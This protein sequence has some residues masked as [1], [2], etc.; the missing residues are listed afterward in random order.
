MFKNITIKTKLLGIVLGS[1]IV[2]SIM[3]T[4]QSVIT[5]ENVSK[6]NIEQYKKNAY[7][8]K[9]NELKNYVSDA[10]NIIDTF[11]QRSSKDK[12]SSEVK[13]YI[14]QQSN[15]L[16][17]IIEKQ[18]NLHKDKLPQDEL[19]KLIIETIEA[20]RYGK[21]GYFWIN[22]FN[23]KMVMHPIKKEL[24]GNYFKNSPK[25]PFVA[26]GVDEL[27]RTNKDIAYISYSFYSPKSKKYVYKSSVVQV[28]K[29][30]GWIIGTG[31]YIDD[32]TSK[33]QKEAIN[34]IKNLRH[35]KDEYFWI[36]D[37][38]PK[39][40]IDPIQPSLNGKDLSS[41]KDKNG[42]HLFNEM[43]KVSTSSTN[44]GLVKYFYS[45]PGKN[46]PQLKLSYVKR[47]KPWNWIIGTGIYVDAIEDQVL[48]LE[49]ETNKRINTII[50]QLIII[51]LMMIIP[52]SII[53]I[54]FINRTVIEP[55]NKFEKGLLNFFR[56]LNRETSD[57]TL[58]DNKSN[59]EIGLMS[60]V[61][62]DNIV[63][64][65]KA[66]KDTEQ[67]DKA[68]LQQSR[69]A[70]M[71]EMISMIAHQWRQPLSAISATS[72][73]LTLKAKLDKLDN[74]TAVEL[75]E[76][77]SE[78]AQHLSSTID[79]FRDFFKPNKQIVDVTY[80]NLIQSVLS[81]I[82]DSI[83]TK[84]IELKQD[85]QSEAVLSSYPNELKQVIL[86]LIKNAEDI[87][88]EKKIEHPVITIETQD[89]ILRVKDNAGG[90]S[91]DII[92]KIFD[93]YFSTKTKKNGTGLGL[94]MSKTIIEDHC[95]GEL[96]VYNDEFGAVFEMKLPTKTTKGLTL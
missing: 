40:I 56:Y 70:Q 18:Y 82:E 24:T 13:E 59:D 49:T 8:T 94:Y 30:F 17:N 64:T 45:K 72:G 32:I 60:K 80:K 39:M 67:K 66:I 55:L 73:S 52:I 75:G 53:N 11:Y 28:F 90:V 87:L 15:F 38:T 44:G 42:V 16:F 5:I 47:F 68:M 41:I 22:D 92:E 43:V 35:G 51:I 95:G 36:T 6:N 88:L 46:K 21:S 93:P 2:V 89:N 78:Y 65:K 1:I 77:I 26:L 27:K 69:L 19:K 34:S 33:M 96:R 84:N 7:K 48:K 57:I 74:D 58:L 3:T 14:T 37:T 54:Y 81:I 83:K 50:W 61:I 76:K 71:G 91:S 20:A 23:Y 79:D 12:L 86:N 29:P 85:L 9:E 4:I 10:I 63:K 62:N 25:V 31:A